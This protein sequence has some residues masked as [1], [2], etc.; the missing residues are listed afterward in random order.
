MRP[1]SAARRSAGTA[2]IV[3]CTPV[4]AVAPAV[5]PQLEVHRVG[6]PP[7]G[8][9]VGAQEAVRALEHALGLRVTDVEDDPADAELTAEAGERIGRAAAAGVDRAL[10]VP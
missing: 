3:R 6:E 8:L 5:E 10:T 9:E 4:D 1:C 2:R 7:A